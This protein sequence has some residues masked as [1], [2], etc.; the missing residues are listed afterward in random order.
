MTVGASV[1]YN[2]HRN[3]LYIILGAV[4]FVPAVLLMIDDFTEYRWD[5]TG[6]A[7]YNITMYLF[8]LAMSVRCGAKKYKCVRYPTPEEMLPAVWDTEIDNEPKGYIFCINPEDENESGQ[9]CGFIKYRDRG[10]VMLPND[11]CYCVKSLEALKEC[12]V[13]D[14][15]SERLEE[16]PCNAMAESIK[17]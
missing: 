17:W 5:I 7:L 15:A 3:I 1:M 14:R 6:S 11:C 8:E 10:F 13:Y 4:T 16:L 2:F 12:L 9:A